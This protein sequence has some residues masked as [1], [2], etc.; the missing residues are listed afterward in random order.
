[1][2]NSLLKPKKVLKD[3]VASLPKV[4]VALL[5]INLPSIIF[6]FLPAILN[7]ISP[8]LFFLLTPYSLR[9][10]FQFYYLLQTL[11]FLF[12]FPYFQ[13]VSIVYTY[14]YLGERRC[15]LSNAYQTA[16]KKIFRL[17]GGN[18]IVAYR[19]ATIMFI[20]LFLY[21]I[22]GIPLL[23]AEAE[24]TGSLF[25]LSL[26]FITFLLLMFYNSKLLLIPHF[27]IIENR[28]VGESFVQTVNLTKNNEIRIFMLLILGAIFTTVLSQITAVFSEVTSIIVVFLCQPLFQ[29]FSVI[30]YKD[31]K[32]NLD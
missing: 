3:L 28:G 8:H 31:L 21:G 14:N 30:V 29:V 7:L 20:A 15:K 18:F 2:T 22:I 1:M 12:V 10:P 17:I 24:I 26:V 4:Y 27:I 9:K 6:I 11:Y 23:F 13:G 16:F 5:L 19:F 32:T 25:I